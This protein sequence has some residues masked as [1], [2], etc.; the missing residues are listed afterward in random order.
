[1]RI[2]VL[3]Y[4]LDRSPGG[5]GRYTIGLLDGLARLGLRPLRLQAGRGR[6]GPD[7]R[8][9][10]GAGLLPGLMTIGQLRLAREAA[11]SGL[12]LVHDPIG[13][14]PLWLTRA[15]RVSTVHDLI[16]FVMPAS[17]TTLDRLIY[18]HWLPRALPRVDAVL[19]DS[20]C[21]RQDIMAHLSL[22]PD[23][24][25]VIPLAAGAS[26][27]PLA[28]EAVRPVLARHGIDGPYLLFVGSQA[29]RKNLPRLLE[30]F[31][32]L[33]RWS[34]RWRLVVVGAGPRPPAAIAAQIHRLGL[35]DGV[36]VAGRVPEEDLPALYNGADLFVF[37]SL[38][39]GFGLPVLEA[40]A[41]G[42]PVVTADRSSLPEVAGDAA[43]LVDPTDVEAIAA[44]LRRVLADE[45]LAAS[46]RARGLAR[47]ATFSWERT[48]R[49]TVAVYESVL[50]RD[51]L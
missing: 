44:A 19:T 10:P 6:A 31:A 50:G 11:R 46:L 17:S 33:R 47:A 30:A 35:A 15:A 34:D 23:R 38:Y 2:G 5:I 42:V 21:S 18:R 39:E 45:A 16:P 27:R 28:P 37:P 40:M 25:H 29:P 3:T 7:R 32:R 20:Q 13:V 48:A 26:F 1:M 22:P 51:L 9:L 24:V 8:P 41:C 12:A 14:C 49:E 4:A 43:L 36:H